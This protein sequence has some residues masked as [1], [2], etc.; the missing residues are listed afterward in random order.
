MNNTYLLKLETKI[1]AQEE[2]I[3][4]FK[5]EQ[6]ASITLFKDQAKTIENLQNSNKNL[7]ANQEK[8]TQA[9]SQLKDQA[10]IKDQNLKNL[11]KENKSLTKQLEQQIDEIILTKERNK[12]LTTY[13]QKYQQTQEQNTSLIE[14]YNQLEKDYQNLSKTLTSKDKKL[15][16]YQEKNQVL[17]EKISELENQE[18]SPYVNETWETEKEEILKQAE[19]ARNE[20]ALEI[21]ELEK[22]NTQL[23]TDLNNAVDLLEE[24]DKTI[25]ELNKTLAKMKNQ[26]PTENKPEPLKT[27]LCSEC[28]QTKPQDQL[29]RVFGSY[30]F[31]LDCSKKA[32]KEAQKE[33]EA[34][35]QPLDFTCHL[36]E[37][38]KTEIPVRMKLDETLQPYSVCQECKPL[39]KEFNEADLI[40]DDLWE[41]YPYSSASEIL[42][43][44]FGIKKNHD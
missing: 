12:E 25:A 17:E 18:P 15:T 32:R 14:K 9:N 1:K 24:K 41:K 36:C 42:E 6:N 40:T 13:K 37:K 7:I 4:N 38:P 21:A 8:L 19:Q 35:P 16:S 27:F 28:N 31:C 20:Q 29:S 26:E 10:K 34:K 39:A 30:S 5:K 43:K 23:D 33:K 2:T 44:E 11:Q 22:E 3:A